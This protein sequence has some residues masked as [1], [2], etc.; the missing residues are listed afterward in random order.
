[1]MRLLAFV[2]SAA[3]VLFSN[4]VLAVERLP[5]TEITQYQ[6][7]AAWLIDPVG[8]YK[9]GILGDAVE[10]GGFQVQFHGKLHEYRLGNDAVFEDR[11]VRLADLTGDGTPEAIVVKSYLDKGAAIA[12]YKLTEKGIEPL[13]ESEPIGMANRWLNPL[14]VIA[15]PGETPVIAAV[16]MPHIS[17]SLRTYKLSG[18]ALKQVDMLDGYTN[19]IIHTAD[20]DLGRIA[21]TDGD[22]REDIVLPDIALKRLAV[23]NVADGKLKLKIKLPAGGTILG[24]DRINRGVARLRLADGRRV[25][26]KLRL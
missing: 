16:V 18:K 5:D 1:M 19:H 13:A 9:H 21:D 6:G 2:F 8:R 4:A 15:N 12:V 3:L 24:L 26:I 22:G 11:R 14:G 7:T 10:A 23:I 20:L 17:G 25:A